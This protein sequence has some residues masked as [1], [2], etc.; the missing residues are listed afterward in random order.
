MIEISKK[1]NLGNKRDMN[2]FLKNLEKDIRKQAEIHVSNSLIS[3]KCPKC[4]SNVKVNFQNNYG[5]CPNCFNTLIQDQK[6]V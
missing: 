3:L 4:D 6:W 2:K 5:T 1:F